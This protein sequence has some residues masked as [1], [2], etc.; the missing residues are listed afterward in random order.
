MLVTCEIFPVIM[1]E[2]FHRACTIS[3]PI[4]CE[5]KEFYADFFDLL[6]YRLHY[7]NVIERARKID[8]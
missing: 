6:R 4:S 2:S 7:Q 3:K 5:A 8:A 1:K